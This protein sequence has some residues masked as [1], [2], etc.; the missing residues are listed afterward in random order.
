M[1]I[2]EQV[3]SKIDANKV[4]ELTR[5]LIKIPSFV[6]YEND[7]GQFIYEKMAKICHDVKIATAEEMRPNVLCRYRGSENEKA[8][9]LVGHTDTIHLTDQEKRKWTV[10]PFEGVEKDNKIYGLGATDMKSA[11]AAMIIAIGAI[12]DSGV[13]LL[14][15]AIL[16]FCVDEEKGS[17]KGMQ[18]LIDQ[19]MIESQMAVGIQGEPTS[20]R[21]QG[22]FKG[23]A[24]YEII[25]RGKT[26][27]SSKFEEGIN[28]I[29]GM[30]DILH[31]LRE[32]GLK[33][34]KHPLLGRSTLS[35]GTME[36]GVSAK[37]VPDYCKSMIEVRMVPGQSTKTVLKEIENLIEKL[38]TKDPKLSAEIKLIR[39]KDPAEIPVDSP[40]VELTR[41]TAED[42]IG[43]L[44]DYGTEPIA[45]GDVNLL[46][47]HLRIPSILF[48]PGLLEI[49]HTPDE[50]VPVKNVVD[51]C[52]IYASVIL[53]YCGCCD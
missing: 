42:I 46:I 25:T 9:L 8:L 30:N 44:P 48:G 10:D 45:G 11:L 31:S 32:R 1:S 47:R 27:H 53:K 5:E 39:G 29:H 49:A 38:R 16:I 21:V 17:T 4:V 34:K 22:W 24:E 37:I 7:I 3:I 18:Y 41:N 23:W 13:K 12:A 15:D 26:T 51:I 35:I 33:Y 40:I 14:N 50:F 36:G 20:M 19:N 2:Q 28:A 43:E 52:K 6:G